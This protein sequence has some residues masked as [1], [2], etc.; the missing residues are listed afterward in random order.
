MLK[1]FIRYY[2]PYRKLFTV[3]FICAVFVALLE[4]AFPLIVNYVVDS[5]LP[6]GNLTLIMWAS[7]ALFVIYI[8]NSGAH[9]VVTYW[10][11]PPRH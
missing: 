5:L 7:A 11:A 10:G 9:Y 6:T 3:T 1:R 8:F 4:L 2:K